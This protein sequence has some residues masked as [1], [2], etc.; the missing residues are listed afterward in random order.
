[1]IAALADAKQF[2]SVCE[3]CAVGGNGARGK[4]QLLGRA[5]AAAGSDSDPLVLV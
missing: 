3:V 2:A 1:M 4:R 5:S